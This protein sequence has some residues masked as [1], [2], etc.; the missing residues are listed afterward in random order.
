MICTKLTC[1]LV[2]VL[3]MLLVIPSNLF[4]DKG[5]IGSKRFTIGHFSVSV[6]EDWD[7]LSNADKAAARKEFA[8]DLGPGLRQYNRSGQPPPKMSDFEIFQK[9]TDGQLIAWTLLV[10]EQTDFLKEILKKE[11]RDFQKQKNLA[12]GQIKSG[13]CRM[14]KVD[15]IDVVRVDIEMANGGKSTNVHFWSPRDPGIITTLMIGIRPN[16]SK[17]TA[18]EFDSIISSLVVSE[19]IEDRSEAEGK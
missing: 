18:K 11:K 6:P 15:S 17:Q 12:G 5:P 9:P 3:F 1:V 14:V 10:P 2:S 4:A 16:S 19:E 7:S 8:S 13:L